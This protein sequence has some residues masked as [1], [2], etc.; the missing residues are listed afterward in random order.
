MNTEQAGCLLG[1][2][3]EEYGLIDGSLEGG[4]YYWDPGLKAN[5]DWED[6]KQELNSINN[7]DKSTV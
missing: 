3:R 1:A 6:V 2:L 7:L 4:S 5:G